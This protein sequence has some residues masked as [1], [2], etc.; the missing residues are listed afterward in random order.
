MSLF[1]FDLNLDFLGFLKLSFRKGVAERER[2]RER[3]RGGLCILAMFVSVVA[4]S[5]WV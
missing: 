4:R 5:S 1:I 3:E 2:E